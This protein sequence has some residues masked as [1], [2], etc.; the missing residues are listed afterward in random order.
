MKQNDWLNI[1]GFTTP[2]E[3]PKPSG[4]YFKDRLFSE[5]ALFSFHLPV[6]F[7]SGLYAILVPDTNSSPRQFRVVYFG[8]TGELS[9]RVTSSHEKYPDWVS[10]AGTASWLYVAFHAMIGTQQARQAVESDLI[11]HYQP[12]CN[13]MFNDSTMLRAFGL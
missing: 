11:S 1:L 7:D 3:A 6:L 2:R 9:K 13:I 5:P 10:E 4:I 12:A 8:E